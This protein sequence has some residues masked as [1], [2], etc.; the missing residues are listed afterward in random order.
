M[1]SSVVVA[2]AVVA[3]A[4]PALPAA[5]NDIDLRIDNRAAPGQQ[6]QLTIIVN[7]D[8]ESVTVDLSSGSHHIKQKKGPQTQPGKIDFTLAHDGVGKLTWKGTLD[9]VFSDGAS[10][11]MPLSFQTERLSTKFRFDV[12]RDTFKEDLKDNKVSVIS[13]RKTAKLEV[14]PFTDEDASMGTGFQE[15]SPPVEIGKPAEVSWFPRK[16]GEILRLHIVAYDENGSFQAG[17]WFPYSVTIPHEDVVFD[18]GKSTIR[19]E[20]EPKLVAVIP[21]VEKAM[22]RF[23]PALKAANETVKLL[24]DGHTDTVGDAGT[25]RTLSQARATAIAKWF[26]AHGVPIAVYARGYGED[27]LKVETPDN[28][29][30]QQNRRAEYNVSVNVPSGYTKI[31]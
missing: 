11:S 4:L 29:D 20:Q 18:S 31:N 6:P 13:E 1:R 21:E 2:F 12:K 14:E 3:A 16:S 7:K 8:V 30:E 5:A 24:V 27:V 9:V 25:N 23:G 15:F 22:K 17:D 28:T 19:P 26:K 10:G